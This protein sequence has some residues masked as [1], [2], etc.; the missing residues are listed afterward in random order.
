MHVN[1]A[2]KDRTSSTSPAGQC[3]GAWLALL[4]HGAN[5]LQTAAPLRGFDLYLVGFHCAK[6][7]PDC[8]VEAHHFCRVVNDDLL[9]CVLFDGNTRQAN[10]I[11]VE[12]IVSGRLFGTVPAAERT[13]W[14]PHNYEVLSGQLAAPGLARPAER[15]LLSRLMNSYGK[16]WLTWRT[17]GPGSGSGQQLPF[18]DPA[19]MWSFNRDGECDEAMHAERDQAMELDTAATKA[20]RQALLPLARP[21]YGVDDMKEDF[22]GATS[23]PGVVDTGHEIRS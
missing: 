9:Q 13:R 16:A 3:R 10:L 21:Q 7:A 14:H 8:Q 4:A 2:I 6:D 23:V 11:G 19:L 15:A 18:G 5:L 1:P 17:H 20:D 22:P 12:Y